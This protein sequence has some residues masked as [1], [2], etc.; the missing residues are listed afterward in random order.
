M[1]DDGKDLRLVGDAGDQTIKSTEVNAIRLKI[2]L[3][4][5]PYIER[6]LRCVNAFEGVPTDQIE[7]VVAKGRAAPR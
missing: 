1:K 2:E 6:I 4:Y 3:G 5:H 7:E